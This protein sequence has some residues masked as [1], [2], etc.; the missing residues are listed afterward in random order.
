MKN[1]YEIIDAHCH[2]YP[3][4][5]AY[6][7]VK[8]TDTFYGITSKHLGTASDLIKQ[9][10]LSGIDKFIVQSVATTP[11]QVKSIN[12]FVASEVS[13][14][15]NFMVGLGTLHQ[16]SETMEE[17]VL[18]LL[19]LG[20]KGVKLH[21]DIQNFKINE[22]RYFIIYELCEKYNLPIL[23]HTGDYRYDNSN[24]NRLIPILETFKN[25]T[26]IGAHFGG[27]SIYDK[28]SKQLC[29]YENFY[30]DC[31]SSFY[32]LEKD[33]AKTIINRY[34][35]DRVLFGTDYPMWNAKTELDYFFSLNLTREEN[36][37]ILSKNA[38]KLLNI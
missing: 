26:I 16:N 4:K 34:G 22:E 6:K 37:K 5:I 24:P 10:E 8:G 25:L 19:E 21:P 33:T 13:L 38:K 18:H 20:L 11:H 2:I 1:G 35:T 31:S 9:K 36:E 7:A 29:G 14:F 3:E 12:E 32:C 17:D 27:W 30:V 28:A 15:G 23:M